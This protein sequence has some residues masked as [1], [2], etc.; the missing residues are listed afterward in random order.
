[1]TM[2][3]QSKEMGVSVHLEQYRDGRWLAVLRDDDAAAIVGTKQFTTLAQAQAWAEKA[4][5]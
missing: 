1:M 5:A 3:Y 4:V 2:I